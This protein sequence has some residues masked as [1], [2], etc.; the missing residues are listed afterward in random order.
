MIRQDALSKFMIVL[1]L[2]F[3]VFLYTFEP[4]VMVIFPGVL[5]AFG[6]GIELFLERRQE[7]VNH[8]T[9]PSTIR[10]IA[11][12]TILALLGIFMVSFYIQEEFM[13][14]SVFAAV[15]FGA[16][17]AVAEE[18]F[19]RGGITDFL[20]SSYPDTISLGFIH[21]PGWLTALVCS[22]GIFTLYHVGRYGGQPDALM[23][24]F[25]GG[26][27]LN[28]VAYKSR[29]ISPGMLAHIINNVIAVLGVM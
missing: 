26:F 24:V 9:E 14:S 15:S 19:F 23:Y 17:M 7:Y 4:T 2:M 29:R 13:L 5:L 10:T 16:L 25:G 11:Y 27:I 1:A 21:L 12:W 20:V 6:L 8:V 22:A 3:A 18:Q 28:F